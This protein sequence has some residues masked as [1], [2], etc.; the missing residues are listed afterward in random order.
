M[1]GPKE[2]GSKGLLETLKGLEIH[3]AHFFTMS[4]FTLKSFSLPKKHFPAKTG[5]VLAHK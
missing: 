3:G 2:V 5:L 1:G 4:N